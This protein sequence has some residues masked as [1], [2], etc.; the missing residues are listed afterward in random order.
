MDIWRLILQPKPGHGS[1]NMAVDEAVLEAC[2]SGDSPPTLRLYAWDPACLSLGYAQSA[3]E[4][5]RD[6]LHA[7]GWE[8]VRRP[9]GGKAVLH[10]DELTYSVSGPVKEPRLAGSVLE[11]YNR[12]A[13]ALVEALRLLGLS[14]Q[15][16]EEGKSLSRV[17]NPVCFEMPSTYEITVGGKKLIGSAQRRSRGGMLQHGSLPLSGDLGRILQALVFPDEMRRR[18]AT[19]RLV[20]RATTVEAALGS[21]V[22]WEQ[23]A[24]AFAAAFQAMLGLKLITG[25]LLPVEQARAEHLQRVK[26]LNPEWTDNKKGEER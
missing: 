9:T 17:T 14:V 12:L 16:K 23:A 13:G 26:Y 15:V 24:Q 11:S 8:L 20:E 10:V 3:G 1:W 5:D 7:R 25:D 2:R 6:R 19:D 4:V 21:S 18:Q 22:S